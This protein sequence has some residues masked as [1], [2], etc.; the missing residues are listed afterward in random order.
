M[1]SGIG[2]AFLGPYHAG[3]TTYAFRSVPLCAR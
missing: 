1:I 2:G 3:S